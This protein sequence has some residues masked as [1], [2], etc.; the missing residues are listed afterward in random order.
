M[1]IAKGFGQ[2]LAK[3]KTV[4]LEKLDPGESS[5]LKKTPIHL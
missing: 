4:K 5:Q 2:L 3:P 1:M